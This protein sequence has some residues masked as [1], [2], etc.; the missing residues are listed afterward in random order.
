M[1]EATLEML[2][3]SMRTEGKAF[4]KRVRR[5]QRL[6][7]AAQL[8]PRLEPPQVRGWISPEWTEWSYEIHLVPTV[9]F[10]Q[11]MRMKTDGQYV[12]N[13]GPQRTIYVPKGPIRESAQFIEGKDCLG[14]P[15]GWNKILVKD[16]VAQDGTV[17]WVNQSLV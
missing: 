6:P 14:I 1:T 16:V 7:K 12:H 11:L 8:S 3:A 2:L 17:L 5:E 9:E 10:R 15:F 13:Y 4:G